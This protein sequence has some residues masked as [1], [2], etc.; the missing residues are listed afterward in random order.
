VLA[1][2]KTFVVRRAGNAAS[3]SRPTR[4]ALSVRARVYAPAEHAA[5]DPQPNHALRAELELIDGHIGD[6]AKRARAFAA[7]TGAVDVSTF[8]RAVRIEAENS[9]LELAEQLRWTPP[10]RSCIPP[11]EARVDGMWKAFQE[12]RDAL[13]HGSLPRM[14]TVQA[15]GARR[16]SKLRDRTERCGPGPIPRPCRRIARA[17]TAGATA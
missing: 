2:A 1:G 3:R 13:V 7:E 16:S 12:L 4:R 6:C 11:E 5:H 14:Y 15:A 9:G 17:G 10:T 8:A